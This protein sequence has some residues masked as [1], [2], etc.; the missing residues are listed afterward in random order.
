MSTITKTHVLEATPWVVEAATVYLGGAIDLIDSDP[1]SRHR[2]LAEALAVEGVAA[3]I[4]CPLCDQRSHPMEPED[5]HGRNVQTLTSAR[6]AVFEWDPLRQPSIGTPIELWIRPAGS[7]VVCPDVPDSMY[8]RLL[9]GRGTLWLN[10]MQDA[11]LH[12]AERYESRSMSSAS[13]PHDVKVPPQVQAPV[14]SKV[15]K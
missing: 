3:H 13:T 12:I 14:M 11:A 7:I 9:G 6:W 15:G 2:Q 8:V 5:R 4:Y 10:S 1:D